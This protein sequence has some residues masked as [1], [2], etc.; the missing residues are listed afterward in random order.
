[1]RLSFLRFYWLRLF[2][3]VLALVM[4][5][6]YLND[7]EG[8]SITGFSLMALVAVV[9]SIRIS[10][11]TMPA[12]CDLCGAPATMTA[13]YGAGYSNAR[14]ILNCTR[15]GRVVNTRPGSVKP[16]KE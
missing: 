14:L 7:F 16:E 8:I 10:R 3:A 9:I 12:S 1:M 2:G 6:L 15:C 13:E 11:N 5:T 4:A